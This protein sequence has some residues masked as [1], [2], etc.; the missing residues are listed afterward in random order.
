MSYIRSVFALCVAIFAASCTYQ[1]GSTDPIHRKFAWFSYLNGDDIRKVCADLGADRYRFV[2][3]G[4]YQ[5]QTRAY[6]VFFHSKKMTVQ[7]RGDANLRDLTLDD[8]LAPWRGNL[9]QVALS[10]SDLAAIRNSLLKSAAMHNKQNG[11]RL[12][13]DDFYWTVAACV[14]GQFH[15]EAYKWNTPHWDD[16]VFDETLILFDKS[17]IEV[18]QPKRLGQADRFNLA[19]YFKPFMIE[20]GENGL[21]GFEGS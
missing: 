13:S 18:A 20:V 15:Y 9:Q 10:D 21:V 5:E 11:L 19:E 6:D 4:I 2:Y 8:L 12:S 3:N 14:D 7:V 1:G 17:G 16:M